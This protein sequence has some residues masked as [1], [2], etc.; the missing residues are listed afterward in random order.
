MISRRRA[1]WLAAGLLFAAF[2]LL[3]IGS[4]QRLTATYDEAGH[5]GYGQLLVEGRFERVHNSKMPFSVLNVLPAVVAKHLPAGRVARRLGKFE[6]GRYPTIFFS[7][8]V[9]A[10][11]LRWATVLY[12]MEAGLLA[13]F[14]YAFDPNILAHSQLITT[15]L[16]ATGMMTIALYYFW[17]FLNRGGWRAATASAFVL[18]L[19]QLAKYTSAYLYLIVGLIVM[20]RSAGTIGSLVGQRRFAALGHWLVRFIVLSLFFAVVSVIVIN[21]G[22]LFSRTFVPLKDYRFKSDEFRAVQS[23]LARFPGLRVPLSHPYVFGLDWVFRDER[24][25]NVTYLYGQQ[26]GWTQ[27]REYYPVVWLYKVPL[28]VHVLVLAAII[29]YCR[30]RQRFDFWKNEWVLLCPIV[31]FLWYFI[32]VFKIQKGLRY[33]LIMFPLVY[34]FTSSVLHEPRRLGRWARVAVAGLVAFQIGSV[35]SYYPHF[36]AYFNELVGDRKLAYRIVVDS[37]LDWGQA[38]WYRERW[39]RRHPEAIFEPDEPESGTIVVRVN[40]LAGLFQTEKFRWL[41]ENFRP[42][43]HIG[44]ANLVY[45]V[46]PEDLARLRASGALE[47]KD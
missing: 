4:V 6:T 13:L 43:D 40:Y 18:G 21:A 2:L 37:N 17:R 36:L 14:L 12:G 27:K 1:Y 23:S 33:T 7:L 46:S 20:G 5:Y 45:R 41:R 42:V 8:V 31:F 3:D 47:R 38:D 10:Y 26:L 19:S 29:A 15:E 11:V 32:F 16:Y 25:G 30:R 35:V 44:Y 34:I 22:F 28:T 24:R 39:L 9:A